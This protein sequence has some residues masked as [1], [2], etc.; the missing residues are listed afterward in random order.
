MIRSGMSRLLTAATVVAVL[1][2]WVPTTPAVAAGPAAPS[3][4]Y[5][6]QMTYDAALSQVVLFGGY[7]ASNFFGDTWTWDGTD[8]TKRTPAHSPSPRFGMG[9]AYDAARGE[10]VLF[11]G[12][13]KPGSALFGDTWTWDGTDWTQRTPAHSPPRRDFLGMAYDAARGQVVLFG[14]FAGPP[15]GDT[16]TWDGTDWTQRTPAHSPSARSGMGMAYDAERGEVVLFGGHAA[17]NFFGDTWT[18]DGTDWTQQIPAHS[19]SRRFGMGMAYDAARGQLVLF[20]GYNGT[21]PF[22][23]DTWT[24]GGTDWTKL[25]PVHSPSARSDMG[26]AGDVAHG[27]VVLFG[28]ASYGGV[29]LDDTWTWDGLDWT[30]LF[31]GSIVVTPR[32][33]PPGTVVQVQGAG[34]AGDEVVRLMFVDSTQGKVFITKV[35]ADADGAFTAQATIPLD[36][37]PGRQH[38]KAKGLTSGEIAKRSFTIT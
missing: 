11:G 20:G 2:A 12:F 3:P 6:T 27:Q 4:R 17:S 21:S 34:F 25:T 31:T 15:A 30:Q 13:G 14:G 10:A 22:L 37:P 1:T 9:M 32:S 36:A 26:V 19:P 8:W 29:Y 7:D 28:G 24:W 18:W 16:W 33:G 35:R 23:G 38:V 5:G